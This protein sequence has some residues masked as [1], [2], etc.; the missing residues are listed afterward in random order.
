M[1][2]L[3]IIF[4][5]LFFIFSFFFVS[6]AHASVLLPGTI[7]TCGELA[8]GG[9]Y[10]LGASFTAST[11][12]DANGNC[13][14][15]TGAGTVTIDGAG[16]TITGNGVSGLAVD[17]RA[18][19][20]PGNTASGFLLGGSPSAA[21]VIQNIT[22]A[23][24]VAGGVNASGN[25]VDQQNVCFA[26]G[27]VGGSITIINATTTSIIANGGT[28][29]GACMGSGGGGSIS[30]SGTDIDISNKTISAVSGAFLSIG[31]NGTL[32]ITY[33][34]TLTTTNA[35][36]SALS[37]FILNG[38]HYGAYGGGGFPMLPGATITS[39]AECSSAGL[40]GA[41]YNVQS[42]TGNCTIGGNGVILDGGGTAT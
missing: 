37:D 22:F 8:S 7:S 4:L 13:F 30:I 1:K 24:F 34:G 12:L 19:N 25:D 32:S 6:P 35:T 27:G 20:T 38:T 23:S 31:P 41:T 18:Y 39:A 2:S 11:T 28:D 16:F 33:T 36:I 10:T 26:A 9:T 40:A 29:F 5:S 42:F 21:V 14:V 15:V 17:A 3:R